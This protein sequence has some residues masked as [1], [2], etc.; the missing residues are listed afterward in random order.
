MYGWDRVR[1]Q[2]CYDNNNRYGENHNKNIYLIFR[3]L[4]QGG[5]QHFTHF[6]ILNS[7]L[8]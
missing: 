3:T 5:S 4:D 1:H 7:A 8:L 6:V 2:W